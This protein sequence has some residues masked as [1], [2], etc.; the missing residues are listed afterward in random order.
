ML[1][2][3]PHGTTVISTN[4]LRAHKDMTDVSIP[5]T[6]EKIEDYA[7]AYCNALRNITIPSGAEVNR[8]SF[9]CSHFDK[10]ASSLVHDKDLTVTIVPGIRKEIPDKAFVNC[11]KFTA[12]NISEGI[13]SIGYRAFANCSNLQ[14]ITIPSS[15]TSV[16]REAFMGCTDLSTVKFSDG[17]MTIEDKAFA[18]CKSLKEIKIPDS[19]TRIGW[20]AFEGCSNL[21]SIWLSSNLKELG[22]HTFAGCLSLKDIYIKKGTLGE[23]LRQSTQ[24]RKNAPLK[25]N[26]HYTDQSPRK[27]L[28]QRLGFRR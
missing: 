4:D 26:V 22:E 15:V 2:T 6:V 24:L 11:S 23:R 1:F 3:I 25:V 16:D 7:F 5:P 8:D 28:G 17:V 27:T 12:V 20:N 13:E 9:H 19:T 14:K 21:T 18:D 10:E